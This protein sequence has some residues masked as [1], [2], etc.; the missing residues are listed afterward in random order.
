MMGEVQ[1]IE[2]FVHQLV[3]KSHVQWN[4]EGRVLQEEAHDDEWRVHFEMANEG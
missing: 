4:C 3:G 2:G 1:K